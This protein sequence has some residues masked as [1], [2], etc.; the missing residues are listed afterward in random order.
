MNRIAS[1]TLVIA[2]AAG[3]TTADSVAADSAPAPA[4]A[5]SKLGYYNTPQPI[6]LKVA[7]LSSVAKARFFVS[8]DAGKTWKLEREII[9]APTARD[10]PRME[11]RPQTDGIYTIVTCAVWRKGGAE[12]DP[13]PG[14]V[15]ANARTIVI[16]TIKPTIA[17]ASAKLEKANP[18]SAIVAVQWSASDANFAAEPITVE[19]STDGG[20]TFPLSFPAAAQ[21]AMKITVPTP[22]GT[23]AVDVRITAKDLAGNSAQNPQSVALPPPPD[24]A[25]ELKKAVSSLPALAE[26]EPSTLPPTKNSS[27]ASAATPTATGSPAHP[28]TIAPATASA[29]PSKPDII[30]PLGLGDTSKTDPVDGGFVTGTNVEAEFHHRVSDHKG[31]S[32]ESFKPQHRTRSSDDSDGDDADR[33]ADVAKDLTEAETSFLPNPGAEVVLEQARQKAKAGDRAGAL[34]IY[35]R[36]HNS[37]AAK[38]AINE[39]LDLLRAMGD[40]KR[41][42]AVVDELPPENITDAARLHQARALIALGDQAGALDALSHV[43]A[44]APEAREAMFLIAKCFKAQGKTAQA[45]K[46]FSQLAG[47]TDEIATAAK[48]EL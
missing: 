32:P 2:I 8:P 25:V 14:S 15:P 26:M 28:A 9:V 43:R 5:P 23:S 33:P 30:A 37:G 16:D 18:D 17:S 10:A 45:K 39:E 4:Q 40:Q 11:F 35:R 1:A 44:G 46:V 42:V 3:L 19:A 36:L 24:P 21:G 47:G 27:D 22:K 7:D 48:G 12:A 31:A 38:S 6:I 29:D 20:K 34:A 13:Q 41:I